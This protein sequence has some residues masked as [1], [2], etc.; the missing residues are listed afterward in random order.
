MDQR[1]GTCSLCGGDVVGYRG[2]WMGTIPPGPDHC[3]HC[4]AKRADDVI[5]MSRGWGSVPS[6]RYDIYWLKP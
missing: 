1:V 5:V 2:V 4:G 3:I 6:T